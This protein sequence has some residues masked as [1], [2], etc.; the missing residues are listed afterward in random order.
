MRLPHEDKARWALGVGA[1]VLSHQR[2]GAPCGAPK[3]HPA[4]SYSP[5]ARWGRE[6]IMKGWGDG[7]LPVTCLGQV[8]GSME[9]SGP[10]WGPSSEW[11]QPNPW[12]S[13]LL[14]PLLWNG[15]GWVVEFRRFLPA[16]HSQTPAPSTNS[17]Q[18]TDR[19][20]YFSKSCCQ[21]FSLHYNLLRK[22]LD[23]PVWHPGGRECSCLFSPVIFARILCSQ[24]RPN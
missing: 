1:Q 13:G 6:H 11:L 15:V 22:P 16:W 7:G 19:S 20:K 2:E 9:R 23:L 17:R 24:F 18:G 12:V 5:H 8:Q 3:W 14:F 21:S 4:A 10:V